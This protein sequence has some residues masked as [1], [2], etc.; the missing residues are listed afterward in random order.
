MQDALAWLEGA[1]AGSAA[2]PAAAAELTRGLQLL[3]ARLQLAAPKEEQGAPALQPAAL[4][5]PWA[6][7]AESDGD[8]ASLGAGLQLPAAA[9]RCAHAA[10]LPRPATCCAGRH[11]ASA[12]TPALGQD[13]PQCILLLYM[14]R[15]SAAPET[16]PISGSRRA[17]EEAAEQQAACDAVLAA[18]HE[19]VGSPSKE[20]VTAA[21]R[22]EL[23][24]GN[25]VWL[26]QLPKV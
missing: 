12:K 22:A 24:H 7:V 14:C 21:L 5:A 18:L 26:Y 4:I 13:L 2:T 16:D 3:S 10:A 25:L 17:E 19:V 23:E 15:P 9:D 20:E 1:K 8:E 6:A 11:R